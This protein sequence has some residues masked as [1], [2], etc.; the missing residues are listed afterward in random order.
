MCAMRE[1]FSTSRRRQTRCALVTGVQTCAL[2]ISYNGVA[3][4]EGA[5]RLNGAGVMVNGDAVRADK[6][7]IAT[8]T[9][10]SVP[11]I[12]GLEDV[13]ALTSTTALELG[14][15]PRSLMVIGGGYIGCELAQM[16][17]RAGA[18][19]TLVDRKSTRLN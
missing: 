1:L 15:L 14:E 18:R 6:V 2:P 7:L 4:L 17:A 5:A 9:S 16:F 12:L 3:Y 11:D 10:P 8:G 13:P 19:V